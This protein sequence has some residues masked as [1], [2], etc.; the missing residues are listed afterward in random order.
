M[1]SSQSNSNLRSP[2]SYLVRSY[3]IATVIRSTY[4]WSFWPILVYLHFHF[5]GIHQ[6]V[7][8]EAFLP[9]LAQAGLFIKF[10]RCFHQFVQRI[11]STKFSSVWAVEIR[12]QTSY[13]SK[14]GVFFPV[15]QKNNALSFYVTKTV[16]VGPKWFWSD[17]ID[18]DL[19]IMIWSWPKWNEQN[20]NGQV[21]IW[22][23]LV[24]NHNLDLTSNSFWSWPF[25]FG[26]DQ[27]IITKSK[28]I[29][30]DNNHLG[31]TKTVLVT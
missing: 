14:R 3:L 24:E 2:S 20:Q 6:K 11:F 18:L 21:Q 29:W 28:S 30:S 10:I 19:T 12:K 26:R 27:I 7:R 31:L 13:W 16:L 23:I 17:Q 5:C 9:E 4:L 25:Y 1:K 22:F 8:L 15:Y